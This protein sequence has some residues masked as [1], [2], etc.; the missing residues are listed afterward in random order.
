MLRRRLLFPWYQAQHMVHV[1]HS[2][3]RY[4]HMHYAHYAGH[5]QP[6]CADISESASEDFEPDMLSPPLSQI[7]LNLKC[8]SPQLIRHCLSSTDGYEAEASV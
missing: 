4:I 1:L 5:I 6:S 3:N 2:I 7:C 8:I